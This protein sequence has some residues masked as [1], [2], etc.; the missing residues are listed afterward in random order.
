MKLK[1]IS[2][3]THSKLLKNVNASS[4]IVTAANKDYKSKNTI[5][6]IW[7]RACFNTLKCTFPLLCSLWC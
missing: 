7:P 5:N 2:S 4:C 3:S 6:E 1:F